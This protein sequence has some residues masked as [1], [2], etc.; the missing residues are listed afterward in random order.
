MPK[1]RPI[2]PHGTRDRY[3][4]E[5][6]RCADCRQANA[7]YQTQRQGRPRP[8]KEQL[9]RGAKR[10]R[11]CRLVKMLYAF[12]SWQSK[13]KTVHDN[14]CAECFA[15]YL[16]EWQRKRYRTD[17]DYRRDE[18][19]RRYQTDPAFRASEIERAKARRRRMR[20]D[21]RLSREAA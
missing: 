18:Y 14:R 11:L 19:R 21:A 7:E 17:K 2:H 12:R 4:L 15:A 9:P 13:G 10:C 1:P 5:R 16:R 20:T 8:V 3:Q 6:C